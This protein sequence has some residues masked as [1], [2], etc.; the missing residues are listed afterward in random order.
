MATPPTG[1]QPEDAALFET[2]N[3]YFVIEIWIEN[4]ATTETPATW[5]AR[6]TH[7]PS[8]ER[9]VVRSMEGM[10]STLAEAFNLNGLDK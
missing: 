6:V 9:W 7:G 1:F 2:L 8:G 3:Q 4:A 10:L 5:R